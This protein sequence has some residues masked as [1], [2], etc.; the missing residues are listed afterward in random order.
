MFEQMNNRGTFTA[1]PG[2]QDAAVAKSFMT[3]VF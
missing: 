1:Q 2:T 3:Q